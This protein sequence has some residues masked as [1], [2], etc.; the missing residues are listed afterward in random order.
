[1]AVAE[2]SES[3]SAPTIHTGRN[4]R[5][6]NG[7]GVKVNRSLVAAK[8]KTAGATYRFVDRHVRPGVAYTYRLQAVSTTGTRA[9]QGRATVRAQ[10]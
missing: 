6:A 8:R 3:A 7:K 10:R 5:L 1:M 9:W 2:G 4:W